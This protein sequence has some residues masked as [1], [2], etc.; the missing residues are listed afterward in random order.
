MTEPIRVFLVDDH[1][2]V[3]RGV[4][5]LLQS[6]PDIVIVGEAGTVA[7]ARSRI[8]ATKPDVALLDVRLPDGSGVDVCRSVRL[9]APDVRCLM[10]TSYDDDAAMYAAV[11]AGASGYVLKDVRGSGLIDSVRR[12]ASGQSLL[13]PALVARV[14]K[15][16]QSEGDGDPLLAGL[17]IREREV[18]AYI[19]DGLT[20]RQIGEKLSLAEKTVKNYVSTM[21]GKLGLQR[22]TQA[23]ALQ[24]STR[25]ANAPT[26]LSRSWENHPR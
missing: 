19:A 12:V 26:D 17:S 9:S 2:V 6:Q 15:R 16:L 22:R 7:Q 4:A 24:L 1:E 20:N 3:R 5:D 13:D 23:V 11:L 14:T 18:L 25:A 8:A 21:L 10:L